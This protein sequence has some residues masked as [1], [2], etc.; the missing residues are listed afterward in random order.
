MKPIRA[1]RVTDD[2][3]L[4]FSFMFFNGRRNYTA[5][6]SP[7]SSWQ[8][9]TKVCFLSV[10]FSNNQETKPVTHRS[11]SCVSESFCWLLLGLG[12]VCVLVRRLTGYKEA[13]SPSLLNQRCSTWITCSSFITF[14][15][16]EAVGQGGSIPSPGHMSCSVWGRVKV[17]KFIKDPQGA[18]RHHDPIKPDKEPRS[19]P[20]HPA[21]ELLSHD[22]HQSLDTSTV[23]PRRATGV[24]CKY[25]LWVASGSKPWDYESLRHRV[26]N[27][28]PA[29]PRVASRDT[30]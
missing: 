7:C 17:E 25:S 1:Q 26:T 29:G 3:L 21:W 4:W 20:R 15:M 13:V 9:T 28:V 10:E 30:V 5:V 24:H 23:A 2:G 19:G 22:P 16:R 27:V 12:R 14:H 11:T 6:R 18:N 8:L